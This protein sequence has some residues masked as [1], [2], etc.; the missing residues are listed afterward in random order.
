MSLEEVTLYSLIKTLLYAN[1]DLLIS[2]DDKETASIP[3]KCIGK[4]LTARRCWA[5]FSGGLEPKELKME[6]ILI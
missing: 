2:L 1:K 4:H 6:L 3:Y 5:T